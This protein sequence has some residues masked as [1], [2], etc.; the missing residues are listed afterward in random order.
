LDGDRSVWFFLNRTKQIAGDGVLCY[1]S[2]N[3]DKRE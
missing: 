2:V 1:E 3:L